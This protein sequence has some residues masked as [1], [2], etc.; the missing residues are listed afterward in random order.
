M[1]FQTAIDVHM[2][3]D[4]KQRGRVDENESFR[5]EFASPW[6]RSA[7]VRRFICDLILEALF[8]Y[9]PVQSTRKIR[10]DKTSF[11]HVLSQKKKHKCACSIIQQSTIL[12]LNLCDVFYSPIFDGMIETIFLKCNY[13]NEIYYCYQKRYVWINNMWKEVKFIVAVLEIFCWTCEKG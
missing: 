13:W 8:A 11:R 6:R 7:R 5:L 2:R 12:N 3:T 4:F 9:T 1:L 10:R